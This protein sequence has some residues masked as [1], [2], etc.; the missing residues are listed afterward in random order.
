MYNVD[1]LKIKDANGMGL[2][3]STDPHARFQSI[4]KDIDDLKSEVRD[5]NK[6]IDLLVQSLSGQPN[7]H[8][9][10]YSNGQCNTN[11]KGVSEIE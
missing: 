11:N 9:N 10:G 3:L 5:T 2:S 7:G 6:K 1:D 4:K 8:S